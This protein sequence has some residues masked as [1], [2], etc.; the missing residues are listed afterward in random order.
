MRLYE[1]QPAGTVLRA[2]DLR[3]D[4]TDAERCLLRGLKGAFPVPIGAVY[5][6]ILCFGEKLVIEADGGQQGDA[7]D[8]DARRTAF[9]EARGCHVLRFWNNDV[10]INL[11]GVLTQTSFCMRDDE[12]DHAKKTGDTT[13]AVSPS[14]S[15]ASRGPLPLP[16]GEGLDYASSSNVTA[17]SPFALSRTVS[18]SI[19][20]TSP[21]E[22]KW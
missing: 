12:G 10:P 15:H 6:D 22:M 5:A 13:E 2:R 4:A 16:M 7:D 1:N 17:T 3:R 20:A 19:S 18:P 11:D 8:N 14:P 9:A 21:S